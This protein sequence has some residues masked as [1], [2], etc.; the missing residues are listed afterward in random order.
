MDP[1]LYQT[2]AITIAA[3]KEEAEY[4]DS[5]GPLRVSNETNEAIMRN[6]TINMDHKPAELVNI[7]EN[8]SSSMVMPRT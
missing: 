5:K 8:V 4:E 6:T 3:K 7:Q 1:S 2:G